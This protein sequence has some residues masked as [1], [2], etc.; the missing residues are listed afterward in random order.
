M[1]ILDRL[2]A[3]FRPGAPAPATT[4]PAP[5]Q[6]REERTGGVRVPY[7]QTQ[8]SWD[9]D[10]ILLALEEH[11]LGTFQ[12][13]G[14]LW[15]WMQRD[16]RLAAVMRVRV[17]GLPSLPLDIEPASEEGTPEELR[18]AE[19]LEKRWYSIFPEK[20]LRALLR[21]AVGMGFAL[22]KVDWYCGDDGLWWPCLT[23]W[24]PEAV[25]Y[26]DARRRWMARQRS[27]PEVEVTP[28]DGWFLWLP[29]GAHSFQ[30]G[31]VLALA[32]PVLISAYDWRDWINFNDAA[33]HPVRKAVVPRGATTTKKD[34]FKEN[35]A[36]LD[37][38]TNTILC[39]Q[40]LDG[41]GFDFEIV[42]LS[43]G[44][45]LD[46]FERS[47][48]QAN[49][50]K[51]ILVLGQSLTTDVADS[52]SRALGDIHKKIGHQVIRADA[53]GFDTDA[54]AQ[55]V[56]PWALYNFGRGE[57]APWPRHNHEPPEDNAA[58]ASTHAAAGGAVQTMNQALAGTGKKVDAVAY[59]EGMGVPLLD[60][61]PADP[62]APAVEPP[63]PAPAAPMPLAPGGVA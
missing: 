27:G 4:P 34:E 2:R 15:Q 21:S 19:L 60:E 1:G 30:L 28:G 31:A 7:I 54:R 46:T 22:A 48:E 18:A 25:R 33:G 9:L 29:D 58:K 49:K 12:T 63:A 24:P 55:I 42:S 20:T 13:S 5:Y 35:L 14:L 32:L 36:A 3:W 59:L 8:T 40:N 52:G 61:A 56:R 62:P 57:L 41:S 43:G 10:D 6:E 38:L 53:E 16:E 17:S 23:P 51:A 11:E 44:G 37:R 50:A 47:L 45:E 26:D 39:E